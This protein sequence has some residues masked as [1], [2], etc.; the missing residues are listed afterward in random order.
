MF[1]RQKHIFLFTLKKKK[2]HN[3]AHIPDLVQVMS[4]SKC[5]DVSK[6]PQL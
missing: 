6:Y 3:L 1:M 2:N 5:I 4:Q